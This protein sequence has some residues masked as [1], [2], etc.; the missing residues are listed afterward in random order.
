MVVVVPGPASLDLERLSAYYVK[1]RLIGNLPVVIFHG[2]S[3]TTNSTLNSSRIQAHVFSIAGFTSYPRLTIAPTSP[4]YLAVHLLPEEQ[5]G[6]ETSR[7]LAVSLLKYFT[8]MP[9]AVKECLEDLVAS[10]QPDGRALIMFD[11]EH[12]ARLAAKMVRLENTEAVA[13]HITTG[14]AEKSISW[15]DLD[16]VLPPHL[17]TTQDQF[18]SP[19]S[20][21]GTN[22]MH[23]DDPSTVSYGYGDFTELVDMFGAPAFLPSSSLRRAPSRP[24][25]ATGPKVLAPDAKAKLHREMWELLDTE[26]AYVIKLDDLKQNVTAGG[27][28]LGESNVSTSEKALQDLFSGCL[29]QIT[30][31]NTE[32]LG[33]L[34]RL[35]AEDEDEHRGS[36][37]E[38]RW[39]TE[40]DP[41]GIE[42][43]AKLLLQYFPRF[44]TCYQEYL[45][46]SPQFPKLLKEVVRESTT[47][48]AHNLQGVG[49]QQ[50][51]SW[52]IEPVQRLPRYSLY[53]D[54]MINQLP[55][56]HAALSKLLKAKDIITDICALESGAAGARLVV[57]RMRTLVS[58]WPATLAPGG[59]LITAFGAVELLPPY[60][61][62]SVAREGTQCLL[63]LFSDCILVLKKMPHCTLSARGL[64]AEVDRPASAPSSIA[65]P[66]ESQPAQQ[67]TMSNYFVLSETKFTEAH[68]GQVLFLSSL[69]P[70]PQDDPDGE[71]T[72][73]ARGRCYY[74]ADS[75]EGKAAR[76][77]EEVAKARIEDR[78]PERIRDSEKWTLR[79]KGAEPGRLGLVSAI[80]EQES[81][82]SASS[83][84]R[85][86]GSIRVVL[87]GDGGGRQSSQP[88]AADPAAD[89]TVSISILG[90]ARY[91][92]EFRGNNDHTS[93]DHVSTADFVPVFLKRLENLMRLH[94]QPTTSLTAQVHTAFMHK[95]ADAIRPQL[96][97]GD[98]ESI[99]GR[100]FRPPS[101]VKALSN[102]LGTGA[103]EFT[104]S[105]SHGTTGSVDLM[106]KPLP[107]LNHSLQREASTKTLDEEMQASKM[108]IVQSTNNYENGSLEGLETTLTTYTIALRS[109]AGN[110]VGRT[111]RNRRVCDE[112]R[113][114]ELYNTLVED[115]GQHHA[116]AQV[117]VDVLFAAFE[118]FLN[119]AWKER[120]GPI[121]SGSALTSIQNAFSHA[122][123][124]R[125]RTDFK[126]ALEHMSPQNRRAFT[127]IIR[128]LAELLEAAGNDGDRG[129][130][131]ASFAEALITQAPHDYVALF[132][133]LVEDVEVL[134]DGADPIEVAMATPSAST[135]D[136]TGTAHS[137]SVNSVGSSFRKRFGLGVLTRE[138]SKNDVGESRVGQIWRSLSKK[139]SGDSDSQHGSLSKG[140]LSRSK[141]TDSPRLLS[142][143]RPVSRDR[144]VSAH[145]IQDENKSRPT[146]A[147]PTQSRMLTPPTLGL[148][149]QNS[150]QLN[151]ARQPPR[152]PSP[153]KLQKAPPPETPTK[154]QS[155][156]KENVPPT[157][158][159]PPVTDL[160]TFGSERADGNKLNI[161]ERTSSSPQKLKFHSPQKVCRA[162]LSFYLDRPLTAP[163]SR[164]PQQREASH[165]GRWTHAARRTLPDRAGLAAPLA[166]AFELGHAGP[167]V[168]RRGPRPPAHDGAGGALEPDHGDPR[169]RRVVAGGDGEEGAQP[170]RAVPRG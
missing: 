81:E 86:S 22:A 45:R 169:R 167:H 10:N 112:L 52:L 4:L 157:L 49:E 31:V 53:I 107:Q 25:A 5:Q 26:G 73:V 61:T 48:F 32:F 117:P 160:G 110:I 129:A 59:R 135:N 113:V 122:T 154:M 142:T 12:A 152:T 151:Q 44:K 153:A 30:A 132:D 37:T 47:T 9:R 38:S 65:S 34:R 103:K 68:E 134:F 27:A 24:L 89:I 95:I 2:P 145:S 92:V 41:T 40:R 3:T 17:I 19:A 78:Y 28:K 42:A 76:W 156:R 74:L 120:I 35:M 87:A 143:S 133:R 29:E 96:P 163:A 148:S 46:A 166:A 158:T 101:P 21:D 168:P 7:G 16:V 144:P 147:A 105:R 50:L 77:S 121:L 119:N 164:T 159:L 69:Q 140:F 146:T 136:R 83:T 93:T 18:V 82:E 63:A 94:A 58:K 55:A 6:D 138:N 70:T 130:L 127:A 54:N 20:E 13:D 165:P 23:C 131:T 150:N 139:A 43:F 67:L 57:E 15:V 51:R 98:D 118:K 102:L 64:L 72:Y 162:L 111:L 75:H 85:A 71:P 1:D 11:A 91:Q 62:P 128:L 97:I 100:F 79:S 33:Y 137:G 126:I 141:S 108:T 109:R 39:I 124:S 125:T 36:P 104:P 149:E 14:L 170:G 90:P 88:V 115:P 116:A 155:S 161:P 66:S 60:R 123:S 56:S 99:R 8:E 80:F 106:N 114:N 84:R